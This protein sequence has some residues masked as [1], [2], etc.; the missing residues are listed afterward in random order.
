MANSVL[1]GF[2]FGLLLIVV[3]QAPAYSQCLVVTPTGSGAGTGADWNNAING[4]NLPG[5][6]TRGNIYYLAGGAYNFANGT[7]NFQTPD[8]G[9]QTI[10]IRAATAADHGTASGC[11][12]AGFLA[13]MAASG[14]NQ[15]VFRCSNC[16]SNSFNFQ[17]HFLSDYWILDGND[18]TRT[19][20]AD[21][22]SAFNMKIDDVWRGSPVDGSGLAFH[23]KLGSAGNPVHDITLNAIEYAGTG[24]D[25]LNVD[26]QAIATISCS[27]NVA[28]ITLAGQRNH[29]Y[30]FVGEWVTI[31]GTANHA[32]DTADTLSAGPQQVGGEESGEGE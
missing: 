12:Q 18:P 22:S 29:P 26:P 31:G 13:G 27:A 9:T 17:V 28:T 4:A 23:V 20:V 10:T 16:L 7:Q 8:N 14:S 1:R 19:T 3:I 32:K 30:L 21:S 6:V 25:S 2:L 11:G 15:V 5:L 24:L